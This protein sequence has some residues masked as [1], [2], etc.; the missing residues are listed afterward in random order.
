[1]H[2][3]KWAGTARLRAVRR[4][5]SDR[6][7]Q[8]QQSPQYA[9]RVLTSGNMSSGSHGHVQTE[10]L[11]PLAVLEI[12]SVRLVRAGTHLDGIAMNAT[13]TSLGDAGALTFGP[14]AAGTA[15]VVVGAVGGPL[16]TT[17]LLPVET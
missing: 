13:D 10:V 9:L 7:Q 1:M 17:A 4:Q 6:Q 2:R 8:Q 5:P 16:L 15:R 3:D 14:G 11:V 12:P